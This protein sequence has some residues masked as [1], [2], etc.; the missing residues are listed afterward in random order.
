MPSGAAGAS[1]WAPERLA[2]Y[3]DLLATPSFE[4]ANWIDPLLFSLPYRLGETA[5]ETSVPFALDD[6]FNEIAD[7]ALDDLID[8]LRRRR[9]GPQEPGGRSLEVEGRRLPPATYALGSL[10]GGTPGRSVAARCTRIDPT[11]DCGLIEAW[12]PRGHGGPL[13]DQ[14][15]SLFVRLRD[16]DQKMGPVGPYLTIGVLGA[17]S[18]LEAKRARANVLV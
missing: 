13:H 6:D 18:G 3:R 12:V 11:L 10:P 1:V 2:L 17:L 8:L 4:L 7:H 16:E 14:L 9:E 15:V 5:A